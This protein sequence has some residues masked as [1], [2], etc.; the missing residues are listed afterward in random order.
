M[1]SQQFSAALAL[2]AVVAIVAGVVLLAGGAW[3]LIAG[4]VLALV[5][6]FLLYDPA[7]KRG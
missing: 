1:T 5:G 2:V 6:A 7:G 4:G 3:G